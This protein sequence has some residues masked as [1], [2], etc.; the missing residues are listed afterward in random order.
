M[1]KL[2]LIDSY[3]TI[4]PVSNYRL[5]AQK[6]VPNEFERGDDSDLPIFV[7]LHQMVDCEQVSEFKLLA[8]AE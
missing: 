6:D 4:F 8:P 2:P 1:L 5:V 3:I 7:H